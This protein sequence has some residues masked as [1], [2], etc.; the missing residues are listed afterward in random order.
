MTFREGARKRDRA[1]HGF[2]ND[3][4]DPAK[5][6]IHTRIIKGL[7]VHSIICLDKYKLEPGIPGHLAHFLGGLV[8]GQGVEVQAY[9]LVVVPGKTLL[10]MNGSFSS[11][12]HLR[13]C[14]VPL[15]RSGTNPHRQA[16]ENRSL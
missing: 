1:T 13:G 3:C 2:N 10:T 16:V 4:G 5:Y 9:T 7:L 12:G 14:R 6:V 15:G 11:E 8:P